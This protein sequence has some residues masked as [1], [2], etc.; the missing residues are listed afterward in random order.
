MRL[1]LDTHLLLWAAE[2]SERLSATATHLIDDLD[3]QLFF[4]SASLW[5]VAIKYARGRSDFAVDPRL[6]RRRLHSHGYD[7]VPVTAEH[8]IAVNDL[9]PLHTDPFDR[10][11]IAQ[12][13]V[14]GITLLT[15]D[16]RVAQYPARVQRV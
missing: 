1:L 4:S 3:N 12:S 2:G 15:S 10:I 5:E 9:P 8:A 16:R 13:L 11:L 6:L 7:E 14:E